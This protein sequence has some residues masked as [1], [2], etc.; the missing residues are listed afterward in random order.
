MEERLLRP[1]LV[2]A[3]TYGRFGVATPPWKAAQVF[4]PKRLSVLDRQGRRDTPKCPE[5]VTFHLLE[6]QHLFTC[7][8]CGKLRFI[9]SQ[10]VA[11]DNYFTAHRSIWIKIVGVNNHQLNT[12]CRWAY[13][14]H[15]RVN[16]DSEG[17][18]SGKTMVEFPEKLSSK[19]MEVPEI[20][21]DH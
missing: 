7:V 8:Q 20:M 19:R 3:F 6:W 15:N 4:L 12:I 10:P 9:D 18:S 11:E 1:W 13:Q 21:P 5:Q 16:T 14:A 17:C 2:V